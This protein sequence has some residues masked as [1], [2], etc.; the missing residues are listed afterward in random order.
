MELESLDFQ[1]RT[2][3]GRRLIA[4]RRTCSS[5]GLEITGLVHASVPNALRG[6]PGRLRQVLTNFIGNAVKFTEHGEVTVQAFLEQDTPAGVISI[7]FEVTDSGIGISEE[8]QGRL[9]QAFTQADSS[10]TLK[11]GGTGLGLAISKQLVEL[12]GGQ[13]GLRRAAPARNDLLV[14]GGLPEATRLYSGH[15]CRLPNER[16]PGAHRR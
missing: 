12:M 3:G 13:V 5:V 11:Y 14:Y 7:K 6:D 4:V 8:V 9:F 10:T 2:T 15:P 16:S 1:L